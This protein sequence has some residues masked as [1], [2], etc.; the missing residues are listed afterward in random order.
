VAA[1]SLIVVW[2][3]ALAL[4]GSHEARSYGVMLWT[5]ALLAVAM[6]RLSRIG[7]E[8]ADTAWPPHRGMQSG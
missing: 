3:A 5:S 6:C 2:L 8:T 4:L 7:P 1:W